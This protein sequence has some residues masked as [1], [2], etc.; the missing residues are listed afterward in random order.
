MFSPIVCLLPHQTPN[1]DEPE[2]GVESW[3][4]YF[5]VKSTGPFIFHLKTP[6]CHQWYRADI[7][8]QDIS[9]MLNKARVAARTKYG[10]I[11]KGT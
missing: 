1:Y 8:G 2:I 6:N 9:Y 11:K 3:D 10:S 4:F 5:G 7:G